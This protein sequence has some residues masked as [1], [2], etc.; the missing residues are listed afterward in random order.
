M[1][2]IKSL[3]FVLILGLGNVQAQVYKCIGADGIVSFG[4]KPCLDT[5]PRNDP[6]VTQKGE[7]PNQRIMNAWELELKEKLTKKA[8]DDAAEDKRAKKLA[9][10]ERLESSGYTTETSTMSFSACL[11]SVASTVSGLSVR[12]SDVRYIVQT[13]IMTVTRICT[14]DGSVLITCSRPDS[15]MVLTKSPQC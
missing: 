3:I 6:K 1:K 14:N 13:N 5:S 12:S 4:D 8:A 9:A 10:Q 11:S 2:Q 15:T 7:T